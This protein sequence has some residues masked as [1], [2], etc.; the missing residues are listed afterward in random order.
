MEP[1]VKPKNK[2]KHRKVKQRCLGLITPPDLTQYAVCWIKIKG[3]CDWPG[4]IESHAAGEYS[5]HFFGDYTTAV[6]KRSKIT[7]FFEGFSLFSHTFDKPN[8]KKAIQEACICLMKNSTPDS[9]FVCNIIEHGSMG[10]L[11]SKRKHVNFE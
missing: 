8:L 10:N 1:A 5:I 6:V 3:F 7:N 9:C 4:V 11:N 2:K